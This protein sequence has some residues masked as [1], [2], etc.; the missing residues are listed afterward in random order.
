MSDAGRLRARSFA[1]PAVVDR[2]EALL[3]SMV[4]Q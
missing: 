1:I 4:R 3:D 2:F